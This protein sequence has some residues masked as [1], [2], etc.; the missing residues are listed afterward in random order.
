MS[1][2][3]VGSGKS[4]ESAT[5]NRC[6][7]TRGQL[8]PKLGAGDDVEGG[9]GGGDGG[10]RECGVTAVVSMLLHEGQLAPKLGTGDD[11]EGGDGGGDGGGDSVDGD[12][13]AGGE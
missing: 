10:D 13:G 4:E 11:V 9:D 7:R 8:A 3:F 12:G 1:C 6:S 5:R 2:E